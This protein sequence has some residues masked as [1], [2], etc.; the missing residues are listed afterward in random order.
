MDR[1]DAVALDADDPLAGRR[2]HFQLASG[3]IYL[4]GN[5]L[6][7]MTDRALE[8]VQE[9]LELWREELIGGWNRGW[10]DLAERVAGRLAP[11][12]GATSD[13][14][15]VADST[16]ANLFKALVAGLRL[17]PDRRVILLVDGEFPTD[18]Y[19]AQGVA[20][21]TGAEVRSV[22]PDELAAALGDDVAVLVR[23]HVDYRSGAR[24]DLGSWT[25]RAHDAG[26]V[27]VWDLS[28]SVG[29]LDL[30]LDEWG[31]DLAVGCSYKFLNGGPGAPAWIYAASRHHGQLATALR[32]WF[33]HA[34]P[35][36]FDDHYRP[37][38][39]AKRFQNGTPPILS[40]A[41][42]A[43]ALGT[44]E[45]VHL[46]Q[47]ERKAG[48]L[49]NLFLDRIRVRCP[50][51][52]VIS[53]LAAEERGAQVS[54]RHPGAGAMIR[55]LGER[56]VVGDHRPPDL[57]RF[58]FAPLSVSYVDVWDAVEELTDVVSSGEWQRPE[59]ASGGPVP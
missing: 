28:H 8:Q 40:L 16:S 35:F 37:A 45:G 21:Q 27:T 39:D 56:G 31:A 11:L 49:T 25:T 50:E 44:W 24:A 18:R 29:A 42:L 5:S 1:T 22:A 54:L 9:A 59:F 15:A 57:L 53:P 23:S 20:E 36:S 48:E 6:G 58:G 51:L 7:A 46:T 17:R 26:A 38:S 33:G 10:V 3:Q 34:E 19:V 32:G 4:D 14:V 2:S 13:E 47:V 12:L 30:R 41:A 43:G 55:A 52:E